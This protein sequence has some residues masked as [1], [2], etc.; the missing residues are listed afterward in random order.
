MY[1]QESLFVL[2]VHD[3]HIM[4][5]YLEYTHTHKI[6]LFYHFAF[7]TESL[8]YQNGL[9]FVVSTVLYFKTPTL[10]RV[11]DTCSDVD[12]TFNKYAKLLF[13]DLSL[14]PPCLSD[15]ELQQLEHNITLKHLLP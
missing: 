4:Y 15:D 14:F 7:L 9:W 11:I 10:S 1:V 3:G 13:E 2:F 12:L 6:N 8:I 5:Y